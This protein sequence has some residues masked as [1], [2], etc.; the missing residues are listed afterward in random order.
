MHPLLGR[1]A[2]SAITPHSRPRLQC[3]KKAGRFVKGSPPTGRARSQ[4][5]K[6]SDKGAYSQSRRFDG[7]CED[8][9]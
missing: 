6:R 7:G 3:F 4:G 9:I 5:G 8:R 1:Y 2:F